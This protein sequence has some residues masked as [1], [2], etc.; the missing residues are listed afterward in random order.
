MTVSQKVQD[1][2]DVS[3]VQLLI[4][5]IALLLNLKMLEQIRALSAP[6]LLYVAIAAFICYNV[7]K[8]AYRLLFH[9]LRALPGPKL[10][11]ATYWYETWFDVF[12]QPG[13]QFMYELDR[14][15]DI[16]GPVIRCNPEEIHVRDS[17]F[18]DTLYT[19]SAHARNKW[20]RANRANGAPGSVASTVEHGHHRLR[21]SALNPF[22]SKRAVTQLEPMVQEKVDLLCTKLENGAKADQVVDMGTAFTALTLDVITEYCYDECYNCLEEPDFSPAWKNLMTNIFVSVPIGRHFKVMFGLMRTMPPSL[23]VKLTPEMGLIFQARDLIERQCRKVQ[24][25]Y[26]KPS[27]ST[28]KRGTEEKAKTVFHGIM[29][30]DLPPIEKTEQRL[31]D[32]AFVL[33]VAGAETTARVLTVIVAHLL[34]QKELY[35]RL[36]QELSVAR[37][38]VQPSVTDLE[39]LPFLKAVIQEGLRMSSPVTNRPIQIAPDEDLACNGHVIPRGTPISMSLPNVLFDSSIFPSPNKFDPDRWL[40]AAEQGQRLDR[41]LVAFGKGTRSCLGMNLAYAEL[42]LEVAALVSRFDMELYDFD[43]ARDLETK[44]DLF[45]G[46]PSKDSRG[47]RVKL[48]VR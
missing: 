41:Y 40:R 29:Q 28:E 5:R 8:V 45:V 19:G 14:L 15:H 46:L 9:P 6:F 27:S 7:A 11:A 25:A 36:Q 48:A 18:F 32:E 20:E 39:S 22:F 35:A 3:R 44:R 4:Q 17:D 10:A 37:R 42:Y 23:V 26:G 43:F 47:V 24:A 16:Y 1:E 33:I 34:Q 31:A 13:G 38:S 12:K 2:C 30:S 21:R